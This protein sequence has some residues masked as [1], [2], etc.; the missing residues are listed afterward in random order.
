[1]L[2]QNL[3]A[4]KELLKT[5]TEQI[6]RLNEQIRELSSSQKED[7]SKLQELKDRVKLRAERR[8][9]VANL[10]REIDKKRAALQANEANKT[11]AQHNAEL[12]PDWLSEHNL[13]ILTEDFLDDD[14]I[15]TERR[16]IATNLLPAPRDL[17]ARINAYT[18]HNI[19]LQR[20]ADELRS[21]STELEDMYRK[22]VSLC[23]GVAEDRVEESLPAL[24]AAVES[25]RSGL[26]EQEVRRVRQFLRR[27]DRSSTPTHAL[28]SAPSTSISQPPLTVNP[29]I[30]AAA[31]AA[32]MQLAED[33]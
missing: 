25:E 19:R 23:T 30:S 6:D 20:D 22:V 12:R 17:L 7:L 21:R 5:K 29:T 15:A 10:K 18:S 4:H 32:A 3:A 14:P 28:S 8:A 16:N 26:G 9:K 13:Q 24:V 11:T 2:T 27:V 31:A 1:M 33:N